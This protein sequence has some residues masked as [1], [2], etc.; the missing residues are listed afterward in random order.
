MWTMASLLFSVML[1]LESRVCI[2]VFSVVLRG[3]LFSGA[4]I[5]TL[6][7][8]GLG[9]RTQVALLVCRKVGGKGREGTGTCVY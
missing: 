8:S 9:E 2:S 5:V 3:V 4:P 1:M 7:F 6:S